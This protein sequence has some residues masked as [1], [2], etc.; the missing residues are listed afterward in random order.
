[1]IEWITAFANYMG[2]ER[3]YAHAICL[4]NEPTIMALYVMGDGI[5]ALSYFV[6][7]ATLYFTRRNTHRI[8]MTRQ[9]RT[10]YGIFI[11][12]CGASHLSDIMILYTGMYRL[13]VGITLAMAGVSA[14]TTILTTQAVAGEPNSQS[15][16]R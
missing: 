7:G 4:T 13:D 10:L 3:Y 16:V 14:M 11:F 9:I 15:S 12:A 2:A 1:M 8:E 5:T 6:I